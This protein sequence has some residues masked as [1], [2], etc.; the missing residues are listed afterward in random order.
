MRLLGAK[1]V[2][3]PEYHAD[4]KQVQSGAGLAPS[5]AAGLQRRHS[6]G[7]AGGKGSPAPI[8][9]R[10]GDVAFINGRA[11]PNA[12]KALSPQTALSA[13]L[14]R[15]AID[16]DKGERGGFATVNDCYK[17]DWTEGDPPR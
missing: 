9:T 12:A 7:G 1:C 3:G 17:R 13:A 15:H 4:L 16:V 2:I 5:P 10:E 8:W 14:P 11:Q 6:T